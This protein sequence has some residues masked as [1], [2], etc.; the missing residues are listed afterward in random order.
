MA[1]GREGFDGGDGG[2][3]AG[4]A[5][6]YVWSTEQ[7]LRVSD[8]LAT[9]GPALADPANR[10]W[11]DLV[12]PGRAQVGAV[13]ATLGLHPL[14]AEDIEERNQRPKI[15]TTEDILQVVLFAVTY[16]GETHLSEID[17]ILG[18]RFVVSAHDDSF[19]PEEAIVLRR[20]DRPALERGPDFVLWAICDAVVDGYFPVLDRLEDELDTLQDDV[21]DRPRHWTLQRVFRLKR[22]LIDLRRAIV[23]AR[24]VFNQLT[25]RELRLIRPEQILYF[26]DVYDHLIRV[27]DEL[28]TDRELVAGTLD[29][30]LSSV[31]NELSGIMKR[32]T[33]VTVILAGI[34]AIGGLFGMSEAAAA[35][36][37]QASPGFWIIVGV[38]IA[39]AIGAALLLRRIDWL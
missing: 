30:Y 36:D 17:L 5:R 20:D 28:D 33:G 9:I 14:V 24:E 31:N 11:I 3:P 16:V 10:L 1:A 35:I 2:R 25:N 21:L 18:E 7:G 29:V 39:A 13:A 34:G 37:G 4:S 6:V 15:E 27:T 8:D 12:D 32:L 19:H 22:E 26:R 23:P 38:T